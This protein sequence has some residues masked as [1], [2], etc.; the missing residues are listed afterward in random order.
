MRASH[1]A[2]T[3]R[4]PGGPVDRAPGLIHARLSLRAAAQAGQSVAGR[5]ALTTQRR[6]CGIALPYDGDALGSTSLGGH[7]VFRQLRSEPNHSTDQN[8]HGARAQ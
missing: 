6:N 4:N 2:I 1:L 8:G 5:G 3:G 7:R